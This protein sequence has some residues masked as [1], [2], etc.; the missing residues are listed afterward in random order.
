MF[1][2][3]KNL[4]PCSYRNEANA[5]QIVRICKPTARCFERTVMP[6]QILHFK[7][8]A[9][10]MLEVYEANMASAV[11]VDTFN[12]KQLQSTDITSNNFMKQEISARN[13]SLSKVA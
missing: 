8:S 10:S 13:Y 3:H 9:D 12:C 5:V 6:G 4:I 1:D 2:P 11:Q 7:A